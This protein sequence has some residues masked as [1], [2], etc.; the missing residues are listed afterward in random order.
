M[1]ER[2]EG[3]RSWGKGQGCQG[4]AGQGWAELGQAG[5]GRVAGQNPTT[6]TTIDRNTNAKRKLK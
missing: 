1:R 6:H 5:L 3:A 2:R 4:H